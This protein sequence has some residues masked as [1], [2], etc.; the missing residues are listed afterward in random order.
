MCTVI[1][2][3]QASQPWPLLLAAN[4]DE[5]LGR[6]WLPPGRHWPAQ[7]DVVA[8]QDALGGGTWLGLNDA[9]IV[10][11]VLN[12]PGTLGPESGKR[13]RGELPLLALRHS[14]AAAAAS[15]LASMDAAPWRS[16]NL[17]VADREGAW[18]LRGT[19][20]GPVT[21][22]RLTAGTHMVTAHDPDDMASLRVARHLSL[23]RAAPLPA[24][25]DWRAWPALLADAE[26]PREAALHV[27]A[28]AGFGTVT[29]TLIGIGPGRVFLATPP[30]QPDAMQIVSV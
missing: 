26:G 2:A 4:R 10:A 20:A 30:G 24:P 8:G 14:T 11:T 27:P 6:L 9:G 19:G 29:S 13:S 17:V 12:R 7:P 15:Q 1:I 3:T 22:R 16:F 23:F 25:P 28:L 18:F 21:A 5:M